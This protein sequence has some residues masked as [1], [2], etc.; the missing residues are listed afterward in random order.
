MDYIL[1]EDYHT[2]TVH[3]HGEGTIRENVL[4]ARALGLREIG[5]T[6][7]G[8]DLEHGISRAAVREMREIVTKLNEE[9]DDI[10]VHLGV[11]A[12]I[13]NRD[14]CLDISPEE[15][16][17]YD[18]VIAGYHYGVADG[19]C[20]ENWKDMYK[21]F[22]SPSLLVKNTDMML[23]AIYENDLKI[24][25]HPG[26]KARIDIV[27]VAKAC[28]DTNTL[29]EINMQHE[30]LNAKQIRLCAKEDV[31]FVISSDAHDPAT[32]GSFRGALQRAIEADIDL[33]RIVN[34]RR[35]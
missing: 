7:H 2:H 10:K 29:M 25:T 11:E 30:H 1:T 3:S 19:Y 26:D 18:Y 27:E 12:N 15:F 24:L 21:G 32:V 13:I 17:D 20:A 9:F 23:R 6:D 22:N 8:P 33:E 4:A 14:N 31:K 5:I 34:I 28:A 16:T 35:K